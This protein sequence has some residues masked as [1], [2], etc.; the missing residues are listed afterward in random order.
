MEPHETV[1]QTYLEGCKGYT[2]GY[3]MG[4]LVAATLLF[5]VHA[6]T[7]FQEALSGAVAF[8]LFSLGVLGLA[9][10]RPMAFYEF[11]EGEYEAE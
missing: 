8:Q 7:G 2:I 6:T 3:A 4:P 11:M 1:E 10:T 5:V 9:Y